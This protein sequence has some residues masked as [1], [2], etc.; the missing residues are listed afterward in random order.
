[1]VMTPFISIIIP[2]FNTEKYLKPC[3]NSVANQSLKQV[4]ILC[5]DDC[6][7]DG[8]VKVIK[9][10]QAQ[11]NRVHLIQM[12]QNA[13]A[14]PCRNKGIEMAKGDFIAFLDSDDLF[15]S[16]DA[17]EKLY[18]AAKDNKVYIAG[19]NLLEFRGNDP[20]QA[21][22]WGKVTFTQDRIYH[23][24][25]YPN[26]HGYYRFIYRRDFLVEH[27][28]FFPPLRRYQD[29]VWFAR[30]MMTAGRFYGMA[31]PV[32]AYR[33]SHQ[34]II[35]TAEK[36]AHVLEGMTQN[37]SLFHEHNLPH[38]FA[39]EEREAK[40]FTFRSLYGGVTQGW[41]FLKIIKTLRQAYGTSPHL[42]FMF[43]DSIGFV[44][45]GII[46]LRSNIRRLIK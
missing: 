15:A 18:H 13:G 27:Q 35:Y 5:I 12:P 21:Q 26:S 46:I 30:V 23:C 8:S 44:K 10:F 33:K 7:T 3:L 42:K 37:L 9:D 25:D 43:K 34:K 14:G 11:D 31:V 41:E 1:M 20:A 40:N 28:L 39:R 22:D 24:A 45:M 17:L 36:T 38:H 29:P 32:Y 16:M 4:E 2:V 6:S 19:G